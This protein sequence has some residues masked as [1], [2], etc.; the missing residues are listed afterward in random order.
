MQ[1]VHRHEDAPPLFCR[2]RRKTS[3]GR[4]NEQRVVASAV[5]VQFKFVVSRRQRAGWQFDSSVRLTPSEFFR[6]K[7]KGSGISALEANDA[8]AS[9]R[10]V[11]SRGRQFDSRTLVV[12]NDNNGLEAFWPALFF[13]QG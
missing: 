13:A 6:S 7:L 5:P 12:P 1:G 9:F 10:S 3:G 8:S 11:N 4:R 2:M